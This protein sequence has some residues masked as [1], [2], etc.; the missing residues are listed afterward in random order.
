MVLRE[1]MSAMTAVVT[2]IMMITVTIQAPA[3]AVEPL[4]C[5]HLAEYVQEA[6]PTSTVELETDDGDNGRCVISVMPAEVN[7]LD[8]KVEASFRRYWVDVNIFVESIPNGARITL[9]DKS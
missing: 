6:A 4:A 1:R 8:Q 9:T 2:A 5:G 7:S 3:L